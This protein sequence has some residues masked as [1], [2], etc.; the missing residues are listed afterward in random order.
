MSNP[1][2]YRL[3]RPSPALA[4]IDLQAL[5]HKG[6]A[7]L[8]SFRIAQQSRVLAL[9][10]QAF[11][12]SLFDGANQSWSLFPSVRQSFFTQLQLMGNEQRDYGKVSFLTHAMEVTDWV[13]NCPELQRY[14][15]EMR[16][17]IPAN[18]DLEDICQKYGTQPFFIRTRFLNFLPPGHRYKPYIARSLYL[19][20]DPPTVKND[21]R[22]DLQIAR[23]PGMDDIA[24]YT[25]FADKFKT[26]Q[27]D[28]HN[29]RTN[30]PSTGKPYLH[31]ASPAKAEAYRQKMRD[32]QK[33]VFALPVASQYK[34]AWV[35]LREE[36]DAAIDAQIKADPDSPSARRR[37]AT[38]REAL[39]TSAFQRRFAETTGKAGAFFTNLVF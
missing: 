24:L 1:L 35:R 8:P 11:S 30:D 3:E 27:R 2:F 7:E 36:I 37:E 12:Q 34:A 38:P 14:P 20:M 22:R 17:F 9:F 5:D 15:A 4:S 32:K 33:V 21:M 29:M 16:A 19:L 31:F 6:K 18:H 23:I 28:L 26:Y 25:R 10:N 39:G 13:F